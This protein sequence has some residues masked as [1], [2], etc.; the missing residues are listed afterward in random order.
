MFILF[1]TGILL[2]HYLLS[3]PSLNLQE[4][5]KG[6]TI[7][8]DESSPS[9]LPS[10]NIQEAEIG[11]TIVAN[12]SLLPSLNIQ[13]AD[14]GRA[15]LANESS[16]SLNLQEADKGRTILA[17]ESPDVLDLL[18]PSFLP[19]HASF[20][21]YN[22]AGKFRCLPSVFVIGMNKCGSTD[23]TDKLT[24]THPLLEY[25]KF[26]KTYHYWAWTRLGRS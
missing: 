26:D 5:D 7:L 8:A 23:L 14:I 22:S 2:T 19:S 25:P 20:C 11:R 17:N 3:S 15:I 21:W 10:L 9:I 18:P 24:A 13:E 1:I 16:P 4:T 12:E 6:R